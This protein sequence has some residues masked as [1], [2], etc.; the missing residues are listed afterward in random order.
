VGVVC[1]ELEV[2]SAFDRAHFEPIA[3]QTFFAGGVAVVELKIGES[4]ERVCADFCLR[5]AYIVH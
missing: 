4:E 3:E 1:V 2:E 5:T